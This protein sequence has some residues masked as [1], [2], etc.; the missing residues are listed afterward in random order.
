MIDVKPVRKDAPVGSTKVK[1]LPPFPVISD[2]FT[3]V[4]HISFLRPTSDLV[5]DLWVGG[6]QSEGVRINSVT[7]L[8][9]HTVR[10]RATCAFT[11]LS[12]LGGIQKEKAKSARSRSGRATRPKT[13]TGSSRTKDSTSPAADL[14]GSAVPTP[15]TA[16][17]RQDTQSGRNTSHP[18]DPPVRKNYTLRARQQRPVLRE[19]DL[20]DP[21]SPADRQS[22]DDDFQP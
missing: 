15:N 2:G 14:A 13:D 8:L 9:A 10:N 11:P 1:E 16:S 5:P 4:R 3:A 6:D 17:Q 22:S 7:S 12:K 18:Q 21:D 19:S 20:D